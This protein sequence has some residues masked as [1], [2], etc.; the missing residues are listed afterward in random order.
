MSELFLS[1]PPIEAKR[2]VELEP[3]PVGTGCAKPGFC[4][5]LADKILFGVLSEPNGVRL[6]WRADGL[7]TKALRALD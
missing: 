6:K 7:A 3:L 2:L 4:S 1:K 5:A